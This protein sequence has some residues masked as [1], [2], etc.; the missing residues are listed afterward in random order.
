MSELRLRK[1]AVILPTITGREDEFNRCMESLKL[2]EGLAPRD[3]EISYFISKDTSRE[4]LLKDNID[5]ISEFDLVTFVDDDDYVG[6]SFF[7]LPE[8]YND[9]E[10]YMARSLTLYLT[11]QH[12]YEDD[13]VIAYP[14]INVGENYAAFKSVREGSSR[15]TYLKD[16]HIWGY[17]Y[18]A[19][20]IK[21]LTENLL[22]PR[23]E[24]TGPW[25]DVC[26][27][28]WLITRYGNN[29]RMLNSSFYFHINLDNRS[30]VHKLTKE[31]RM[32]KLEIVKDIDVNN[33][34]EVK[35]LNSSGCGSFNGYWLFT[36]D[37]G[38]F[39]E[40][41]DLLEL[42]DHKLTKKEKEKFKRISRHE[43]WQDVP[44]EEFARL[45]D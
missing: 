24:V 25:E 27:W 41:V 33:I 9:D 7:S 40:L 39:K 11:K 12:Y 14:S 43:C 1:V 32:E 15:K 20:I 4:Q 5:R 26:Y 37:D 18:P 45:L 19:K 28:A 8:I 22:I 34:L 13:G 21:E 38:T 6:R 30:L 2:A 3:I 16:C 10:I 42:E 36:P 35:S 31:I 29:L 23:P 44:Y 17:F